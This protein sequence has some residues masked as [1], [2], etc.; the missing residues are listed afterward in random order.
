M[1]GA[2]VSSNESGAATT[3]DA[4][5]VF[6]LTVAAGTHTLTV[7]KDS[8]ASQAVGPF[9]V[10]GGA[11]MSSGTVVV[12][13]SHGTLAIQV[14]DGASGNPVSGAEVLV[15]E[16]G[17]LA[18]SDAAGAVALALPP[19]YVTLRTTLGNRRVDS[20]ILRVLPGGAETLDLVL[21]SS[22]FVCGNLTLQEDGLPLVGA[23]V[24]VSVHGEGWNVVG[25]GSSD[26][27]GRFRVEVPPGSHQVNWSLPGWAAGSVDDVTVAPAQTVELGTLT[28]VGGARFW[29]PSTTRSATWPDTQ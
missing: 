21:P 28:R 20:G 9:V 5:G 10:T 19:G 2:V 25:T 12:A 6:S 15:N 18:R 16:L 27:T 4:A 3:T 23:S 7:A 24:T 29:L 1:A 26:G 8:F 11:S 14:R 17:V 22:G 13:Q